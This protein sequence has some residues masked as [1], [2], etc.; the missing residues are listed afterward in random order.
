MSCFSS[1]TIL[2]GLNASNIVV[3]N[4]T[5]KCDNVTEC[6]AQYCELSLNELVD[7]VC[8]SV[9]P[10]GD[11]TPTPV[12][13]SNI[14][15]WL[16]VAVLFVYSVFTTFVIILYYKRFGSLNESDNSDEYACERMLA[17]DY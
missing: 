15:F 16:L 5:Q 7:W 9:S 12:G 13:N 11:V 1:D 8:F 14:W 6:I 3:A 10:S 17:G 2:Y 4:T